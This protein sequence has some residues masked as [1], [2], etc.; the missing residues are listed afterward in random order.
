MINKNIN[1]DYI[2]G[3]AIMMAVGFILIVSY[4]FL[5]NHFRST[6]Y[7]DLTFADSLIN[8]RISSGKD[9]LYILGQMIEKE[10]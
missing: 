3:F 8:E 6:E 1:T 10:K 9:Y 4:I 2:R 7:P 5:D